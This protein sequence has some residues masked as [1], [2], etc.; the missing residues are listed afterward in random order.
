MRRFFRCIPFAS[1]ICAMTLIA[2]PARCGET[3]TLE[4]AIGRAL[5]VAPALANAAANSDLNR[6]RVDEAR[7]PLYP[8]V[9]G[10]GDYTQSPGY[11][12]VIT[13][14]G[15]TLGQLVFQYTAFDGGR[16]NAQVR[17]AHYAAEAA[18]L[19]V[20]AAQAQIVFDTTVAYFD[21]LRARGQEQALDTNLTRLDGY[22]RIV[23]ALERSGRSIP[24]DVLRIRSARDSAQIALANSHQAAGHAS[25][26]L[27]SLIGG[28][29][30][31]DLQIAP[32][33]DLPTPP[34]TDLEQSP[35]YKAADRQVRAAE[36]QVAAAHDE[37]YPTLKLGATAG[38][39][40]VDPPK[41]F[42]HHLG[43]SYDTALSV[44]LFQGG[45]V[46]SHID[47][48]LAA[49]HVAE[50]QRKQIKLELTRDL[51]DAKD[52]YAG[53]REQLRL[54]G[55]SQGTADDAFAL[56]WTRFLG[57]GAVTILE[58]IDAYQQ[59]QTLRLAR[60]DQDFAARQAAAQAALLLGI[61]R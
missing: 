49:Q 50:A 38:W 27:A 10:A 43:A 51:A 19:G 52:R 26:V 1:A 59:A 29:E 22:A 18:I 53:A 42:G 9:F 3:I 36:M 56:T 12:Q 47:E 2:A 17:A 8:S 28:D 31:N 30:T 11:D 13:N 35:A 4:Q 24:N 5:E 40:G 23:E 57:G 33:N 41:T 44:P 15:Q 32:V 20:A 46:R 39:L 21:L 7:A 16:R 55:Q 45:L 25:I 58:V 37:R 6:A 54:L 48:A 61:A 60:F 14:R 34:S